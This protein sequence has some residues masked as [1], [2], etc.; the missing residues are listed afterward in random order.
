MA[1]TPR[2]T[3]SRRAASVAAPELTGNPQLDDALQAAAIEANR[4][5]LEDTP[6][7][8]GR[9]RASKPRAAKV[10]DKAVDPDD[11]EAVSADWTDFM[12]PVSLTFLQQ[13]F[14]RDR[15]VIKR[16]LADLKPVGMERKNPTY[17]FLEAAPYL[18]EPKIDLEEYIKGMRP[19]DLPPMLQA[20][21]WDGQLKKLR[22][23][24]EAGDLWSTDAVSELLSGALMEIRD[25][26]LAAPDT[27]KARAK[28]NDSQYDVFSETIHE[29]LLTLQKRLHDEAETHRRDPESR[30]V[31]EAAMDMRH[32]ASDQIVGAF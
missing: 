4:S 11:G 7:A 28:L 13:V 3:S 18:I 29:L 32:G 31:E 21:F 15:L 1:A 23:G 22:F 16:L 14:R 8:K 24:Q 26:L 6:A 2:K 30:V 9:K 5:R 20:V 19:Q 27:V 25:T 12:K 17:D 10:A